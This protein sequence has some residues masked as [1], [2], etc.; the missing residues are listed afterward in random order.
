LAGKSKDGWFNFAPS[1]DVGARTPTSLVSA[2]IKTEPLKSMNLKP[3]YQSLCRF[4]ACTCLGILAGCA[5]TNQSGTSATT[6]GTMSGGAL[7]SKYRAADGRPIE[8]GKSSESGDGLSFKEPHMDKCW[9]AKGF[10][11][12]G[13]DVLYIAP[14]ISTLKVHDDE[15]MPFE[16]AKSKLPQEF[17][18]FLQMSGAFPSVVLNESDIKPGAKALK[19]ENT[20]IEYSKGG[21]GARYFVGLYGGGQPVLKVQGNMTDSGKPVFTFEAR[22]SGVSAGA[23]MT[24]A[25]M[26]D[27]DIQIEDIRSL[28]LDVSDFV[29][30]IS[31]KYQPR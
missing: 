12:T 29:A 18:R 26:K 15:Q 10:N 11:F 1:E 14:T 7:P 27:E 17:A 30:A 31:G 3:T 21:G 24:G 13:Y 5:T 28:A 4:A 9:L 16:L 2:S 19:L 6:A 8:I 25:F 20:I 22:R 23:R